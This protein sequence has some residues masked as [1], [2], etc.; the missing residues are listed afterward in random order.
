MMPILRILVLVLCALPIATS[1]QIAFTNGVHSLE[2]TGAISTYYNHR[3]MK[4]GEDNLRKNRFRLRDAQIQ[5]EGRYRDQFEYEFQVDFVDLA[6]SSTGAI[7]GEN[8]GLMDAYVIYKGLSFVDIKFGYGKTPYSRSSQV[9]FIFSPYWQR[10]DLVRGDI[11]ARRDVG[12]TLMKSFWKQRVHIQAG[13]YNGIGELSL[14]G[15]ND[16]SGSLEYIGRIDFAYP[17]RYRYRDIDDRVSPVLMV[18]LGL[19]ARYTDKSQPESGV[20]TP[21]AGGEYGIKVIDGVKS[22]YGFD[23]SAQYMG[24]S[25]QFEMHQFRMDP[26]DANS[27]LYLGVDPAIHEGYVRS[28]GYYGQ[29]NYF[30][31]NWQSIF[32]ARYESLNINDLADGELQRISAAYAYQ[33]KG[34][35]AMFK[36]QYFHVLAEEEVVDPLRWTEQIRLGFQY[37]FK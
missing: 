28:G 17:A 9:P 20:F 24:F 33:M 29:L 26:R 18:N 27:A 37:N 16:P 11:F 32:S 30:A 13:A 25:A 4:P 14:R 21:G 12:I 1:A 5:I 36:V 3:F 6:G 15:D 10:V 31:K 22:G 34:Y 35:D 19:N 23:V 8:P 2:I 7:D